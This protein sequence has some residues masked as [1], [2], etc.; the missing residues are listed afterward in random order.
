MVN[1]ALLSKWHVHADDYAR[2]ANQ[3]EHIQIKVVWDENVERGQE[4][5]K[6]LTVPFEPDLKEVLADPEIDAVIVDTPTNLHK[7]IIILAAEYKKHI[8]TEKILA[9]T[10]EECNEIYEAVNQNQVK[11]M[12][13]L[14]RLT[15]NYYLYAEQVLNEGLLGKLTSIRCRLA[16]N[17][18]VPLEGNPNGWLPK[19]FFNKEECGGGAFIDLGAHPIYLTNRL[20]G[21]VKAVI[22]RLQPQSE[23]EVDVNSVAIIEYENGALG[24]IETGFLSSGSPFQLELYGTE[25]AL[26]IEDDKIRLKSKQLGEGWHTPDTLPTALPL[27]M[28]QWIS[29]I[30]EGKIPSI[31]EKDVQ[32]LTL[33]NQAA[34]LS[35]TQ[36]RRVEKDEILTVK[37]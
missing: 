7:E 3:N 26:L 35:Q 30:I 20:A 24:T 11:M 36:G 23:N 14:P 2:Q 17:G 22:A 19:H 21:P 1:V 29:S 8:F 27:P 28:E 25:G 10:V 31:T 12:V 33:I 9:F 4:W 32:G 18:A 13:S 15:E 37:K 34:I 16:H 5:A 6:Q